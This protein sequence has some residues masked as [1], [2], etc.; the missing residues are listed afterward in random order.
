MARSWAYHQPTSV[1]IYATQV[2]HETIAN[3]ATYGAA[4]MTVG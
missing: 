2:S 3:M 1:E 4:L